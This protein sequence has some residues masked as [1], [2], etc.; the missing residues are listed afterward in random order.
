MMRT[1]PSM[2]EFIRKFKNWAEVNEERR[3][4]NDVQASKLLA[5]KY[6][7]HPGMTFEE[8]MQ[9]MGRFKIKR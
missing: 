4:E 8:A 5:E 6:A 7:I 9:R 2:Q 1:D 3:I